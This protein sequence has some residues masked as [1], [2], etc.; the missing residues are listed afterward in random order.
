MKITVF[1]DVTVDSLIDRYS[2]GISEELA[3]S[4]FMVKAKHSMQNLI[5]M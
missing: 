1:F 3:A 4:I 2:T 5:Q